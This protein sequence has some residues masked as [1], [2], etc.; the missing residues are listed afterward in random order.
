MKK[1]FRKRLLRLSL[2]SCL[3]LPAAGWAQS[4]R[5]VVDEWYA[6][7][8]MDLMLGSKVGAAAI[9]QNRVPWLFY[10]YPELKTLPLVPAGGLNIEKL[11]SMNPKYVVLPS[12]YKAQE[13]ILKN[14]KIPEVTFAFK[15]FAGL[16]ECV[17]Q[18]A[19]LENTQF[20]LKQAAD[21]RS[22]VTKI[23]GEELLKKEETVKKEDFNWRKFLPFSSEN[24]SQK[25]KILHISSLNPLTVDGKETIIDEWINLAGG[26]NAVTVSGNNHDMTWEQV[27]TSN[28]DI[29]I[30]AEGAGK[31][32]K[33]TVPQGAAFL[34]AIQAGHLYR[35]PTGI[36]L[37]DRYG[38]ELPLQLL[39]VKSI[40][41]AKN[42]NTA[43]M[44]EKMKIFYERFFNLHPS[45]QV[46]AQIL[47]GE[48]PAS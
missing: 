21:Y 11:I 26:Q 12:A 7:L 13:N 36:F 8:T 20:A 34:P 17:D 37:W 22:F 47:K 31:W 43:E 5:G 29:I 2:L 42:P 27:F 14:A 9:Y 48:R 45:D 35:N 6:H 3:S 39:W 38:V 19:K 30:L 44:R 4:E 41:A 1:A 23:V 10:F 33:G 24:T 46:L 28:P 40:I 18:S 32:E 15:D 25:P 16:L